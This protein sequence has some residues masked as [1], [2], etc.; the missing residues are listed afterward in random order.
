V[1]ALHG[2]LVALSA[3]TVPEQSLIE[4]FSKV[5]MKILMKP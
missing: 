4:G 2:Q 1:V 5:L 3:R